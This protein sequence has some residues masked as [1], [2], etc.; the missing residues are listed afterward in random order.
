LLAARGLCIEGEAPAAVRVTA[1]PRALGPLDAVLIAVKTHA[2]VAA[3]APL[4]DVLAPSVPLISLQNGLDAV[5][6]VESALGA[7]AALALAPTTE[8]ALLLEPGLVRHTGRGR[9]TL[10]WARGHDGGPWLETCAALFRSAGLETRVVTPIEPFV[11][12]KAIVNAAVN[13]LTALA[14]VPNGELLERP[15]LAR[16]LAAVVR[17]GAAV[18]AAAGIALPFADPV[19]YANDVVRSSAANRSSML[20]D[21]ERGRPTEI[22]AIAGALVRYAHRYGVP[23]PETERVLDEVRERVKA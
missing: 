20:R 11:W 5:A 10:G 23:T 13:P 7:R 15:D 14:G 2:T 18:A 1:D 17:E 8:A 4:R 12:A 22:E 9:T 19:A 16:R 6:D 21:V 3:L